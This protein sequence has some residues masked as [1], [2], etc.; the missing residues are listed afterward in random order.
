MNRNY[1]IAMALILVV[2]GIYA[3]DA[4]LTLDGLKDIYEKAQVAIETDCAKQKADALDG[5]GK[6]LDTYLAQFKQ[7]GKLADYLVV[8]KEKKRF[9]AQK[10]IPVAEARSGEHIALAAKNYE[11]AVTKADADKQEKTRVLIT[12]Y[13]ARLDAFIKDLMKADKIAEAKL[14]QDEK[15]RVEFILAT[16]PAAAKGPTPNA[17]AGVSLPKAVPKDAVEFQ[18]HHYKAVLERLTWHS[19]KAACEGMGGHLACVGSQSEHRYLVSLAG[20]KSLW[21]G[22]T[23]EKREGR[24]EWVSGEPFSVFQKHWRTGEPNN[25]GGNE[26]YLELVGGVWNDFFAN[27]QSIQGYIC[28]WDY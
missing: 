27:S 12:Q 13:V 15:Q 26:H 16:I 24:W 14:A 8:E 3:A 10:T 7:Q 20:N 21:L 1:V 18:G 6:A 9:V 17:V 22:G 4:P 28:E 5:Y 11:E 25:D 2:T 23:D 19:A